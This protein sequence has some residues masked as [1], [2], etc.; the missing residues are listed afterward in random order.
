MSKSF[1]IARKPEQGI[2]EAVLGDSESPA[3]RPQPR[4]TRSVEP[5][6]DAQP[7]PAPVASLT[8]RKTI[9]MKVVFSVFMKVM[10]DIQK[11]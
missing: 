3:Q 6:I 8:T 1:K 4:R 2:A 9:V 10:I 5:A 7:A 11:D